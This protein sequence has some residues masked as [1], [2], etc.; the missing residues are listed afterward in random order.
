M[1]PV[2]RAAIGFGFVALAQFIY[3]VGALGFGGFGFGSFLTLAILACLVACITGEI[4]GKREWTGWGLGIMALAQ[5]FDYVRGLGDLNIFFFGFT[6]V[7]AGSVIV[8]LGAWRWAQDGPDAPRPAA[9]RLG[10]WLGVVGG[11]AYVMGNVTGD[12]GIFGAGAIA[13]VIGWSLVA[14][15][16]P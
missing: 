5:S 3:F 6:L 13:Q 10:A 9:F 2:P 8:A 14:R 7:M 11:G 1:A 4:V 12:F 15:A 16:P